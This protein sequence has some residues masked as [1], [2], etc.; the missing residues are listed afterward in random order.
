M[1]AGLKYRYPND[2]NQC[3]EGESMQINVGL[4]DRVIRII[5]GIALIAVGI[6]LL[7]DWWRWVL[8]VVGAIIAGTGLVGWCCLYSVFG[9]NTCAAKP[10]TPPT[11]D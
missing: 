11:G 3:R 1:V 5:V 6:W 7:F 2:N 9:I 10:K 4:W 8:I